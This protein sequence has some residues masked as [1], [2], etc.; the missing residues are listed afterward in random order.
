MVVEGAGAEHESTISTPGGGL[1]VR[2]TVVSMYDQPPFLPEAVSY[3]GRAVFRDK[4]R[5]I[6]FGGK[7]QGTTTVRADQD[8][9]A[10]TA[11]ANGVIDP[12]FANARTRSDLQFIANVQST[13][14]IALNPSAKIPVVRNSPPL[15]DQA[16]IS[17][18]PPT[19][20]SFVLRWFGNA[21]LNLEVLRTAGDPLTLLGSGKP[22][23]AD[24]ILFPG[25]GLNAVPSGGKMPYDNRG[26]PKGGME[27]ATWSGVAPHGIYGLGVQFVSGVPV[28]LQLNAFLNGKKQIVETIDSQGNLLDQLDFTTKV[29]ATSGPTAALVYIPSIFAAPGTATPAVAVR[30]AEP[31]SPSRSPSAVVNTSGANGNGAAVHRKR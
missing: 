19:G 27:V 16:L 14:G 24:E 9:A 15:S 11:L 29:S 25:F 23:I 3:T 31:A 26:G 30:K 6:T 8:S 7:G 28:N 21:D 13:S 2:G 10:E 22:L 12:Q 4:H 20:L 17:S 18:L 5:Q 1:V